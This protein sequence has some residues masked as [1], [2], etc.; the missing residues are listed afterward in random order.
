MDRFSQAEVTGFYRAADS[1]RKYRRAEL[2]DD[3]T[4]ESLL[5]ELYCDPLPSNGVSTRVNSPNTTLI[6][7]RK[8]TGKSTV[9]QKLQHDIRKTSDRLTAYVDIKTIWDSS[10]VDLDLRER[11]SKVDHALSP[12]AIERVLMYRT[13]LK[14]VVEELKNELSKKLADSIWERIKNAFSGRMDELRAELDGFLADYS[15][16]NFVRVLGVKTIGQKIQHESKTQRSDSA[17]FSVD[18]SL[19]GLSA[20]SSVTASSETSNAQADEAQYSDVL[21]NVFNPGELIKKLKTLLERSGIRHLYLLIDDFSELPQ[22]AMQVVVDVLLA[23]LN[24]ASN[25]FIKLKIAA[26]PGRIYLGSIDRTKIDEMYL[27]LFKLYGTADITRLEESGIEFTRRLVRQRLEHYCE[28]DYLRFFERNADDIFRQ[29]FNACL[30]NPRILGHLMVYLHESQISSGRLIGLR[31]LSAAVRRF[32]EEKVEVFFQSGRFLQEAFDERSSI[33]SLKELLESFV[34]RARE[35]RRH[36]SSV[37]TK[38]SGTPPTSHFH[39]PTQYEALLTT[40]ELNFFLTKYFEMTDRDGR[41]VGVFALN[42]GLCEKY[43]VT[44]GRPIGE[45]E[46]RLYF[47]ERIFDYSAQIISYLKNNQEIVC[48]QCGTRFEYGDLEKLKF[49]NMRCPKCA[50]G[51]CRVTNLSKKYAAEL[52]SVSKELLL[53]STELGILQTLDVAQT[54]LRAGEIAEELDCSYQLVSRR[55]KNLEERKLVLRQT[56]EDGKRSYSL[57]SLAKDSYFSAEDSGDLKLDES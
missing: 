5:N 48:E 14:N 50:S 16:E 43:E 32:Y 47:V 12:A 54:G 52:E 30:C 11:I 31:S 38:I 46:F 36:S 24:N 13:F 56:G 29:L 33:F 53:P 18:A 39:V 41:K 42:A 27:D 4:G 15:D 28:G 23:P 40:L 17:E 34:Q 37:F 25:E 26:Y 44:F 7:G 49:F 22:D 55:A 45:R 20:S 51:L 35:L 3:N 1:L 8:G 2:R 21:I 19:S 10:Q 9:F 57:T 6:I